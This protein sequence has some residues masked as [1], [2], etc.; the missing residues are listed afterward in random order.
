METCKKRNRSLFKEE[1]G[2]SLRPGIHA[3][4]KWEQQQITLAHL[5][6]RND[7]FGSTMA[8]AEEREDRQSKIPLD[9]DRFRSTRPPGSKKEKKRQ[10]KEERRGRRRSPAGTLAQKPCCHAMTNRHCVGLKD[11]KERISRKRWGC[12]KRKGSCLTTQE[13]CQI[14]EEEGKTG[15]YQYGSC[16]VLQQK[17]WYPRRARKESKKDRVLPRWQL[18]CHL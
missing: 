10:K 12:R 8:P 16:P 14:K 4:F 11:R 7:P 6:P 18:S 3:P 15:S 9:Q 13:C 5:W 1:R 17:W 2:V